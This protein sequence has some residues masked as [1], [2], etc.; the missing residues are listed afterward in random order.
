MPMVAN[1]SNVEMGKDKKVEEIKM[2]STPPSQLNLR[3]KWLT[4]FVM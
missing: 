4:S 1:K 3:W 2:S